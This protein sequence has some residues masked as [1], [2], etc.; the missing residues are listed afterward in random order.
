V[1]DVQP[2]ARTFPSDEEVSAALATLPLKRIEDP[3][4]PVALNPAHIRLAA[5]LVRVTRTLQSEAVL[6]WPAQPDGVAVLHALASLALTSFT[7]SQEPCGLR[8]LYFP[9]TSR[10]GE[11]AKRALIDRNWLE[12]VHIAAIN[13]AYQ[14]R[15]TM[16]DWFK[17]HLL[18]ARVRDLGRVVAPKGRGP[19]FEAFTHP[20]I[21][22]TCASG[23]LGEPEHARPALYRVRKHTVI[24]KMA[25]FGT[26][27]GLEKCPFAL[28]GIGQDSVSSG[29][30]RQA[31]APIHAVLV[32]AIQR[33]C[34]YLGPGWRRR[35]AEMLATVR[36]VHRVSLPVLAV[37]DDPWIQHVLATEILPEHHAEKARDSVRRSTVLM[38]PCKLTEA[39]GPFCA[40]GGDDIR[41]VAPSGAPASIE[42]S[43]KQLLDDAF[44]LGERD[45][46]GLLIESR[47]AFRRFVNLP[48]SLAEWKEYL[49]EHSGLFPEQQADAIGTMD[50]TTPLARLTSDFT[51]C[52]SVQANRELIAQLVERVREYVSQHSTSRSA[53]AEVFAKVIEEAR[54]SDGRTA[55]VLADERTREFVEHLLGSDALDEKILLC[56]LSQFRDVADGRLPFP[57]N[58]TR[59]VLFGP[60]RRRLLQLM[61]LRHL[62]STVVVVAPLGVA[63]AVAPDAAQLATREALKPLAERLERLSIAAMD[64]CD[65]CTSHLPDLDWKEPPPPEFD[66]TRVGG[67]VDLRGAVG[68]VQATDLVIR[69]DSDALILARPHSMVVRHDPDAPVDAFYG[70][71]AESLR[72]GD[73]ICVLG[74]DFLDEVKERFGSGTAVAK[75]VRAYHQLVAEKVARLPGD[76]FSEKAS[77][78]A[79]QMAAGGRNVS[80]SRV[81]DWIRADR[82][83]RQD[84]MTVR[85][86]APWHFE[87]F[88]AFLEVLGV[89]KAAA[90]ALWQFG[91]A[92][93]RRDRLVAAS[94]FSDVWVSILTH[95]LDMADQYR[96]RAADIW[97]IRAR[98][99]SSVA[100]VVEVRVAGKDA[101]RAPAGGVAQ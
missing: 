51:D 43:Y 50:A 52:L 77:R 73:R 14:Q 99:E 94:Q 90:S 101:T 74:R 11:S 87:D 59:A 72:P 29:V 8:V 62:P 31:Q 37:T 18:M 93:T 15:T 24:R 44:G 66:A 47:E 83:L 28:L 80:V 21:G 16:S 41:L 38:E 69:T 98:A 76:C 54:K 81:L 42:D 68:A 22:E 20:L 75:G 13:R 12:G 46:H 78:I 86:H 7:S 23:P 71:H 30:V 17:F 10:A 89:P 40:A 84:D 64:C 79:S 1:S 35:I 34:D 82:W 60:G 27:D 70:D 2:L 97:A 96:D 67:L 49:Q 92:M 39:R 55:V 65:R 6:C 95:T 61:G 53:T 19:E 26:S 3:R 45:V 32:N 4:S 33:R 36:K 56:S 48:G 88:S 85:P 58:L 5:S 9:W 91:V 57:E 100:A 25:S 63:R